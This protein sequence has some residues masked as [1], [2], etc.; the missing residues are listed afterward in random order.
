MIYPSPHDGFLRIYE[1]I[2]HPLENHELF[3]DLPNNTIAVFGFD[4]YPIIRATVPLPTDLKGYLLPI[5]YRKGRI[6]RQFPEFVGDVMSFFHQIKREE[7]E[8]ELGQDEKK[9]GKLGQ[10]GMGDDQWNNKQH[11]VEVSITPTQRLIQQRRNETNPVLRDGPYP[12]RRGG[13]VSDRLRER[14]ERFSGDV[15]LNEYK[16]FFNIKDRDEE[17]FRYA[18]TIKDEV[19]KI[20]DVEMKKMES[21]I[22]DLEAQI[23]QDAAFEES[24]K[25]I[26]LKNLQKHIIHECI[27]HHNSIIIMNELIDGSMIKESLLLNKME[28]SNDDQFNLEK[29]DLNIID[30][31]EDDL[32][33]QRWLTLLLELEDEELFLNDVLIENDDRNIEGAYDQLFEE[34]KI[35]RQSE[36]RNYLLILIPLCILAILISGGLYLWYKVF[37]QR[38]KRETRLTHLEEQKKGWD[39]NDGEIRKEMPRLLMSNQLERE[40]GKLK[41]GDQSMRIYGIRDDN[42][43]QIY[44]KENWEN[45]WDKE[46]YVLDCEGGEKGYRFK[47]T[48]ERN[49]SNEEFKINKENEEKNNDNYLANFKRLGEL[50]KTVIDKDISIVDSEIETVVNKTNERLNISR[51]SKQPRRGLSLKRMSGGR[52]RKPR[53]RNDHSTKERPMKNFN[54]GVKNNYDGLKSLGKYETDRIEDC[55]VW[56]DNSKTLKQRTGQTSLKTSFQ[57]VNGEAHLFDKSV[58]EKEKDLFYN[59]IGGNSSS[60]N[61]QSLS[62]LSSQSLSQLSSQSLSQSSSSSIDTPSYQHNHYHHH[63]HFHYNHLPPKSRSSSDSLSSTAHLY[64]VQLQEPPIGRSLPH[65]IR[66]LNESTMMLLNNELLSPSIKDNSSMDTL[67]KKKRM[68]NML[69]SLRFHQNELLTSPPNRTINFVPQLNST[70]ILPAVPT[71]RISKD[72]SSIGG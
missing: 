22:K 44:R 69:P 46:E 56:N 26:E 36:S 18:D 10:D 24:E 39:V 20:A 8:V 29:I 43:V 58:D 52:G 31:C 32:E 47:G 64:N 34:G 45:N 63:H 38:G 14:R 42:E 9:V 72:L 60:H 35:Q 55:D 12:G 13:R 33:D 4:H 17:M 2:I 62:Q 27:N 54:D 49:E 50:D 66:Q 3:R 21:E 65:A 5:P 53:R 48:K 23:Q 30:D 37:Y 16:S 71:K 67:M 15:N 59:T 28:S 25:E 40:K 11:I 68:T 61:I 51:S 6:E 7:H 1:P 70:W 41:S 57:D 19:E